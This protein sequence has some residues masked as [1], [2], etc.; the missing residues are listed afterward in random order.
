MFLGRMHFCGFSPPCPSTLALH[1]LGNAFLLVLLVLVVL[2]QARLGCNI[3]STASC[4][5]LFEATFI[6]TG[7]S[8]SPVVPQVHQKRPHTARQKKNRRQ[9]AH[10]TRGKKHTRTADV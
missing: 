2:H 5:V 10:K 4:P 9:T 8:S 1:Y 7:T 3:Y 6:P